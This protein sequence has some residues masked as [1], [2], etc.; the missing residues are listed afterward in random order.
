VRAAGGARI[1][2]ARQVAV[3]VIAVGNGA[4]LRIGRACQPPQQVISERARLA[5]LRHAGKIIQRVI[6]VAE[7]APWS[8]RP[9]KPLNL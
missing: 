9:P 2:L 7:R 4:A 1:S 5:A 8:T 3:I 6:A